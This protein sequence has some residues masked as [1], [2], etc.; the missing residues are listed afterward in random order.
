MVGKVTSNEKAS[1]SI[2][3]AIMGFS[4]YTT[5]NGQLEQTLA[6][7]NGT[8][9]N[10]E[11]NEAT[12]WGNTLEPIVLGEMADRLDISVQTQ[13]EEAAIHPELPL[14][15]SLDGRGY[16]GGQVIE[17]APENGLYVL[18]DTGKIELKGNGTMETKVT[19][20]FPEDQ[21]D[22][23][24]G[25]LQLQAQLM[26]TGYGWG[27]IGVLY[28]GIELRIFLYERHQPTIDAITKA[29]VDFDRRLKSDPVDWYPLD[30]SE[31]AVLVFPGDDSEPEIELPLE[32]GNLCREIAILKDQ[33]K[34]NEETIKAHNLELQK[35]MGN[36]TKATVAGWHLKWPVRNYKAQPEKVVPAKDA[37]SKRQSTVTIKEKK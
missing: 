30:D 32:A 12:S 5:R 19:S 35:L 15:A 17:H 7:I 14:E 23:S 28:R 29:V 1:A 31:D 33:I 20:V 24:R 18:T 16:G 10:W 25:P 34:G 11:G 22:F 26:C 37:Y 4:P 3:P 2:I 6:H 27:A 36:H 9:E 8:A 13:I 21:P